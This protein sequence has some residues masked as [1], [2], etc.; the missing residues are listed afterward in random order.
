MHIIFQ[1]CHN[2]AA[3]LVTPALRATALFCTTISTGYFHSIILAH[4]QYAHFLPRYLP[5]NGMIT[6]V[7]SNSSCCILS[8]HSLS[9]SDSSSPSLKSPSRE[10]SDAETEGKDSTSS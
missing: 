1:W 5:T 6:I 3:A 10:E 4:P 8:F 9:A 2:G 7:K